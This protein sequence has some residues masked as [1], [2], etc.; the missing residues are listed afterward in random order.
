[1]KVSVET[2][3]KIQMNTSKLSYSRISLITK[4]VNQKYVVFLGFFGVLV[5]GLGFFLAP[6]K[7][8]ASETMMVYDTQSITATPKY[9]IWNGTSWG[10]EQSA[11]DVTGEIAHQEVKYAPT[12]DEAILVIQTSTGQIS[13]QIFNGTS[14][15]TPTVLGT[16]GTTVGPDQQAING[17]CFDVFYEQVSGDAIVVYCDSTADPNYRV[18]DGSS[19]SAET[20]IDIP[21]TGFVNA[22]ETAEWAGSD[23]GAFITVDSNS[24]VYGMRWTGSAWNNMGNASALGTSA[25]RATNKPMD[26]AFEHNSGDIMFAWGYVTPATAHFRYRE[27]SQSGGTLGSLTNVTNG[28][29]GGA[30]RWLQL[31]ADPSSGSDKLMIALEDAGSD[32]N[33]FEWSGTAWSAVHTEHTAGAEDQADM[34]FDLTYET[35]SGHGGNAWLTFGNGS[36]VTRKKWSGGAWG[37]STTTGDDTAQTT[38]I[39]Q[40]NSGAVLTMAYEDNTSASDDIL[41]YQLTGGSDTWSSTTTIWGGPVAR[42]MGYTR[43]DMAAQAYGGSNEAIMVYDTQTTTTIPKYRLWDGTSWGSEQSANSVHGDTYDLRVEYSPTRN[44]AILVTYG[45]TGEIEAQVWNGTSWGTPTLITTRTGNGL[46]PDLQA[47]YGRGFDIKYENTSGDAI[48][49]YGDNSADPNYRVWNGTSWSGET[50]IDIP[51]TRQVNWVRLADDRRASSDNLALITIDSNVDVYGLRW[52][53]SAWDNMGT[54]TTWDTTASVATREAVAVEF[55]ANSGDIM[56]IWGDTTSTDYYY[57]TYSGGTLSSATLLDIPASG[58]AGQWLRLTSDYSSGSDKIMFASEDA[59][60]DLNTAEWS[61]SAWTVHTEHSAGT[62][63]VVDRNFDIVY[64][65]STSHPGDAWLVWGNSSTVSRKK[66]DAG[67]WGSATTAGDDTAGIFLNADPTNGDLIYAAYQDNTSATDDILS[68]NITGG[69]TSW[70][71]TADTIWG[72]PIARNMGVF[73]VDMSSRRFFG[74]NIS[75]TCDAYDQSTDCSAGAGTIKVSVNGTLQAQTATPG[76]TWTLSGVVVPNNAIVTVFIDGA[77]KDDKAVAVTKY[78]GSG[79]ITGVKLFAEHIVIGSNQNTSIS[80]SDLAQYDYSNDDDIIFEA[81]TSGGS[82]CNGG[83]MPTGGGFCSDSGGVLSQDRVYVDSGDTWVTTDH[84]MLRKVEIHGTVTASSGK[85]FMLFGTGTSIS[86]GVSTQM[87]FCVSGGTFTGPGGT[88]GDGSGVYFGATTGSVTIPAMNYGGNLVFLS[89]NA[90]YTVDS[91]TLT[92]KEITFNSSGT[93][94]FDF[95][96]NNPTVNADYL[97]INSSATL[98][99]G[100]GTWTLAGTTNNSPVTVAGTFNAGT[101][102][103]VINNVYSGGDLTLP[104]TTFYHLSLGGGEVYKLSGTLTTARDLT[105]GASSTLDVVA[106]QNYTLNVGGNFTKTGTFNYQQGTVNF[107]NN[108]QSSTISGSP[109]FYNLQVVTAGKDLLFTAGETTTVNGL[110]TLTGSSGAGNEVTLNSTT[111]SSAWTINHQGTENI[112][113]TTVSWSACHGSSTTITATGTGNIDGGNNGACWVFPFVVSGTVYQADGTT[114]DGAG[115]TISIYSSD[116]SILGNTTTSNGSGNFTFNGLNQPSTGSVVTIWSTG[117]HKTLVFRYGNPCTSG[118][119]CTGLALVTNQIRLASYDAGTLTNALLGQC[120]EENLGL[121][122]SNEDI[123]FNEDSGGL[124]IT[125]GANLYIL[126]NGK[127]D[128]GWQVYVNSMNNAGVVTVKNGSTLYVSGD[129]TNTGTF[130]SDSTST[131]SLTGNSTVSGT[132]DINNF[133]LTS[134][135]KSISIAPSSNL[136]IDGVLTI[137]GSKGRP[138]VLDSSSGSAWTINHQ[139]TESISYATIRWSSCN[140]G[141]TDITLDKTSNNGG[142][143][144][145]CWKF[146]T[147]G[148]GGSGNTPVDGG[149]SGGSGGTSGGGSGGGGG[150]IDGGGS[151]G[152]GGTSGGGSGGGGGGGSP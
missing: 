130:N 148:G 94:T 3:I 115:Y 81:S 99:A 104:A 95:S 19:W 73:R 28:N 6:T 44:E 46:G 51:T 145:S 60:A 34:N 75:G 70:S 102:T 61:G 140:V 8:S 1:M 76:G 125:G 100:Y 33:T 147:I 138:V 91:G 16:T 86:C 106:G 111:G 20:N 43:I 65:T 82:G 136:N 113:Y 40:P 4:I 13:A 108:T 92:A 124:T 103:F 120:D 64:E 38:M 105:I 26:V 77:N 22:I 62:E 68:R 132:F 49:V 78:A 27:Y 50:N 21:T 149:T 139:G 29:N 96:V 97:N 84:V 56:Y 80:N 74:I 17:R 54:S 151:G 112:T 37:T 72:G 7:A 119:S 31:V 9:R 150:P 10:S 121:Y 69:G 48:I 131:V 129:L 135:G 133:S 88:A 134:A 59:G 2:K 23:Q 45:S 127:Y 85:E 5:F 52:T 18:W 107:N 63:D 12:R 93:G 15:G 116:G 66:W 24:D 39:A 143:N 110:L 36:T 126:S 53:G 144:G 11:S 25:S 137:T 123:G 47:T 142:H 57:R 98:N 141:S 67:A 89:T 117:T 109:T 42:N 128:T 90:T 58:G 35:Y 87:P 32:I 83:T 146:V 101:S 14:W 79:D 55:E 152:S 30:V 118:M 41:A 114:P 122:C 71:G